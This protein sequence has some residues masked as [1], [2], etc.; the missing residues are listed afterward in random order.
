[1]PRYKTSD[2]RVITIGEIYGKS[3]DSE[4]RPDK[5]KSLGTDLFPYPK[6]FNGD[7]YTYDFNP[8]DCKDFSLLGSGTSKYDIKFA[9]MVDTARK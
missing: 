7:K 8:A 2:G 3:Y 1:M 5:I 9:D 4:I 6:K